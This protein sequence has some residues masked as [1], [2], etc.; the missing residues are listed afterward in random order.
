MAGSLPGH[1]RHLPYAEWLGDRRR[2]V[3]RTVDVHHRELVLLMIASSEAFHSVKV[4]LGQRDVCCQGNVLDACPISI[5][6]Y[7]TIDAESTSLWEQH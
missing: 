6:L 5:M 2:V 3:S 1:V 4:L 7:M